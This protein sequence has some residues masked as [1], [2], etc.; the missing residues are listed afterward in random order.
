MLTH[1]QNISYLCF[2]NEHTRTHTHTHTHTHPRAFIIFMTPLNDPMSEP[3]HTHTHRHTHTPRH[4]QTHTKRPAERRLC[5]PPPISLSLS[6]SLSLFP[7]SSVDLQPQRRP[8][9]ERERERETDFLCLEA[10]HSRK[11]TTHTQRAPQW[12]ECSFVAEILSSLTFLLLTNDEGPFFCSF[13]GTKKAF[14][15]RKKGESDS[16]E[17]IRFFLSCAC[18]NKTDTCERETL[19]VP[20]SLS[21]MALSL[22]AACINEHEINKLPQKFQKRFHGRYFDHCALKLTDW[23]L[24]RLVYLCLNPSF[25]L[26][27][28]CVTQCVLCVCVFMCVC[29]CVCVCV[30][31][32]CV[33]VCV[34]GSKGAPM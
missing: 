16:V 18:L 25:A 2:E 23:K 9:R 3:A 34:K 14:C 24:I 31:I 21:T 22:C 26:V 11:R 7:T 6:L 30:S 32:K 20:L 28:V 13:L 5:S 12:V 4:T 10:E 15:L 19:L 1:Q 8:E 17:Y 33:C 29:V 27:R